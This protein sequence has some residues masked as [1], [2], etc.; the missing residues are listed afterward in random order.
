MSDYM[1]MLE[2]HLSPE[3]NRAVA[4]IEG[5]AAAASMPLFLSGGAMRDMGGGF[6]IRDLDFTVEGNALKLAKI[7]AHVDK[8]VKVV[9]TDELRRCAELIFPGNVTASISSAVQVRY[10]K[11]G[12]KPQVEPATIHEDL[13]GRDFTLN[14]I[15]LSL[16]RASRGLLLDPTNGQGDLERRELRA[17]HNYVMYDDPSRMLRLLRLK[18]R[19]GFEIEPRTQ[20]QYGNVREAKLEEKIPTRS[21]LNELRNIAD[22]PNPGELLELLARENLLGL[23][24]P[25]LQA[26]RLN[27][28]GFARLQKGRTLLPFGIAIPI[29]N[30]SLFL[31]LVTEKLSPKERAE[32][33]KHLGMSPAEVAESQK[34]ESRAKKLEQSLKP[35]RLNK[36]SLVY[37]ALREAP[38][39]LILFLLMR[40]NER[41]VLDRIRNYLQKYLPA[42]HE[43]TD[44]DPALAGIDPASPKFKKA[45]DHVI[46][47]KLDARVRK[48]PT[49]EPEPVP[50]GPPP[51]GVPSA[52]QR[53]PAP[54][55]RATAP[56][57]LPKPPVPMPK[58][59]AAPAPRSFPMP[60]P[61]AVP[62][63]PPRPA[64]APPPAPPPVKPAPPSKPVAPPKQAPAAKQAAPAKLAAPAKP[65]AVSKAPAPPKPAASKAVHPSKPKSAPPKVKS[66]PPKAKPASPKAKSAPP[67]PKSRPPSKKGRA[68]KPAAPAKKPAARARSAKKR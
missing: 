5:A 55:A 41:L 7:L 48:V 52:A 49:P 20:L 28:A 44:K 40:S 36:A 62:A 14:A 30:L 11:V 22:E 21:L 38:G 33:T 54:L 63:P 17:V 13:R 2:S 47:A 58:A 9:A 42:A 43:V 34:L 12:G 50:A 37:Q 61:K 64:P 3:Q 24:S 32:M 53:P 51:K 68:T 16:S 35:A 1:F 23:F 27:T 46:F 39:E 57:I 59:V 65:A 4:A 56:S 10:G 45:K 66:A 26:E 60:A 18:V 15:A 29:N 67:K 25:A 6:P 8:N 19:L 31:F